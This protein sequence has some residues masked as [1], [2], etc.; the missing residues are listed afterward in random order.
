MKCVG[1]TF[2][3]SREKYATLYQKKERNVL[4][5]LKNIVMKLFKPKI[6]FFIIIIFIIN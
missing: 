5:Y 2:K 1:L 3:I 6:K 4:V